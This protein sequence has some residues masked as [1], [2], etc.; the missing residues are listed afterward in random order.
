MSCK[1]WK[2]KDESLS[3]CSYNIEVEC[4]PRNRQCDICGW[5]PAV[6]RERLAR[7]CA[8]NGIPFPFKMVEAAHE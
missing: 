7:Y 3:S 2:Q 4:S 1:P 6:S 5:N 8:D